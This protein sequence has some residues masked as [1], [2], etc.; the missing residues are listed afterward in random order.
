MGIDLKEHPINIGKMNRGKRN[1]ITDVHG[2]KIGHVTLDDGKI[3]TGVTAILPHGGNLFKEK[4][5]A[6][7]HVINGFGKSIGLVQIEELG[8]IETPIVMTNTLSVGT[9]ATALVRYMLEENEDIGTSTGTVNPVVCECNDGWLNDIRGLHVKEEH[10]FEAINNAS[11]FCEEGAVGAG[12]GMRC[13]GL[14]GGIGTA[15]R[16][17]ELD[18]KEYTVGILVLSNFGSLERLTVNGMKLG[19]K[20][21]DIENCEDKGSIITVLATDIPVNERQLKRLCKRVAA[22]LART[23]SYYG[24]GSG[25]IVFGFTT[26]NKVNHYSEKDIVNIRIIH[27]NKIESIFRAVVEA[28]E[29]AVLSSMLHGKTKVGMDGRKVKGISEYINLFYIEMLY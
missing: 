19:E 11:E 9:C 3:K 4:V 27:E 8:T 15:S 25:D 1:S 29:E 28:T 7:A 16:I 12:T 24:N 21:L 23:G 2:V 22:G 13:F 17:V 20:I 14:K 5:V 26:A 6:A 10:V 18:G